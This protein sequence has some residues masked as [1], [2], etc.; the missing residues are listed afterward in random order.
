MVHQWHAVGALEE[1]IDDNHVIVSTSACGV[2]IPA[3]ICG[4]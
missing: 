2:N 1:M 4:Q 3:L